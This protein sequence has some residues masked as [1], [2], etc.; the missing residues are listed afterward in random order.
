MFLLV[1]AYPGV[2]RQRGIK[3]LCVCV[4]ICQN[5]VSNNNV[6]MSLLLIQGQYVFDLSFHLCVY[7]HACPADTFFNRLAFD[8]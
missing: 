5:S 2:P 7:I 4:C 3:R 8:F 1:L 6:V